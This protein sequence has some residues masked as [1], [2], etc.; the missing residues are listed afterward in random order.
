VNLKQVKTI[1][2]CR[3][4]ILNWCIWSYLCLENII[5]HDSPIFQC[6]M[7]WSPYV[8]VQH[9]VV[10]IR[11]LLRNGVVVEHWTICREN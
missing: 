9:I 7:V 2:C 10:Y 11:V 5:G 8:L 1:S 6:A 4:K 3:C